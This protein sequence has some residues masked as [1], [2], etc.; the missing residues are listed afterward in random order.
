VVTHRHTVPVHAGGERQGVPSIHSERL[1][2]RWLSPEAM[3][4]LRQGDRERAEALCGVRF[5]PGW[6]DRGDDALFELRLEDMS[7]DRASRPWL[8]RLLVLADGTVAGHAGF[9][10][11]PDEHGA[12]E[13]GYTVFPE[14]RR[15]GYATEAVAAL[16]AWAAREHGV[17]LIRAS[18]SPG[19]EASRGVLRGLGFRDTGRTH[20][21]E[22]DGEELEFELALPAAPAGT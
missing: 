18:V 6:P 11:K 3:T 5:P 4:A 1:E 22:V 17:R 10:G 20:W 16:V 13:V 2:L 12:A 19:N 15:K 9:H 14:H 21:D 7:R 8:V